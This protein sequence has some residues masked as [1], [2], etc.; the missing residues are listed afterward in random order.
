MPQNGHTYTILLILTYFHGKFQYNLRFLKVTKRGC[1]PVLC[2]HPLLHVLVQWTTLH[3]YKFF[4]SSSSYSI[5]L[6]KIFL[7]PHVSFPPLMLLYAMYRCDL[8]YQVALPVIKCTRLR[9]N[10]LPFR[11]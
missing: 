9:K 1:L 8:L 6:Y 10:G 11:M 2:R 5:N 7:M 3:V 4:R